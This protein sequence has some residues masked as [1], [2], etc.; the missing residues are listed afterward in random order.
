MPTPNSKVPPLAEPEEFH[1]KLKNCL[2]LSVSQDEVLVSSSES[3]DMSDT[4][5]SDYS[6]KESEEDLKGKLH[7]QQQQRRD[8]SLSDKTKRPID[9]SSLEIIDPFA[10]SQSSTF[11]SFLKPNSSFIGS[12]QSGR[13]IYEVRVDLKEVDLK[14][15]FLT[16]FLTIHGLTESHPE[17]TT[18]FRAEIIGPQYSFYTNHTV[19][20]SSKR[21]DLQHWGRFPSWRNLDFNT[22]NDLANDE[23]YKNAPNDEFLYMRWKELFLVPDA[24]VKDIRGASFA[25]FYYICFNQLTGSISG[26]YFHKCS[27]KF[28]QLELSHIPDGGVSPSYE[29]A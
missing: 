11:S 26:L 3:S 21:N 29:Y 4:E 8:R 2:K 18:F 7:T 27:D 19:W 15:S 20:G 13:S 22:E 10:N 16:G 25:G 5:E 1:R 12:Q 24:T 28:Q 9:S 14:T 23:I 17:I 6:Q